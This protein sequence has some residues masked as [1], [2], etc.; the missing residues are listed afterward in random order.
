MLTITEGLAEI[1][2]IKARIEKKRQGIGP[3]L[4]RPAQMRDP[5]EK[6]GGV[7]QWIARELQAIGDMEQRIIAIRVAIQ[8]VNLEKKLE[9]AGTT[10]T[11]AE[12]LTWR[13]EVQGEWAKFVRDAQA[14]LARVRQNPQYAGRAMKPEAEA[15]PQDIIVHVSE[16]DLAKQYDDYMEVMGQLDARLSLTNATT[17]IEV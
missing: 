14:T 10:R 7:V 3:Y 6:D 17:A 8:K 13:R 15:G 16:T 11:I 12:W 5:M 4:V 1:K 2:T 9:I